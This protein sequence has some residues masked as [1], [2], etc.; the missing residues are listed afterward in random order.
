MFL[1][2]IFGILVYVFPMSKEHIRISLLYSVVCKSVI[3]QME[4]RTLYV[5]DRY[6]L[7]CIG[8]VRCFA[9]TYA[10]AFFQLITGLMGVWFV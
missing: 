2:S 3:R 8:F 7:L 9:N 4:L 1:V 6:R 10:G 5:C